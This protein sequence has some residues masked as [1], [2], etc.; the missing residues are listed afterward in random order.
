[1]EQITKQ[2]KFDVADSLWTSLQKGMIQFITQ[3]G[4]SAT[5][6]SKPTI[7]ARPHWNDVEEYLKGNIDFLPLLVF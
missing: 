4:G 7:I 5:Y 3:N 1:M 2:R 6:Y